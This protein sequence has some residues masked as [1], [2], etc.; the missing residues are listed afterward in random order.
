VW[1]LNAQGQSSA[2]AYAVTVT[3]QYYKTESRLELIASSAEAERQR[4]ETDFRPLTQY[5]TKKVEMPFDPTYYQSQFSSS[6]MSSR[7]YQTILPDE[8]GSGALWTKGEIKQE[9]V[10]GEKWWKQQSHRWQHYAR[11]VPWM[12]AINGTRGTYYAGAWTVF[13]MHELAITS[14]FAAAYRLGADFPH[15]GD[16]KCMRLF[17]LYLCLSHAARLRKRDR[18]GAQA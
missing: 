10:I 16:E 7:V 3:E 12:W 18:K 9:L 13:N 2:S 17:R 5:Y 11:V 8:D 1:T 4:G 14:G 6:A 15:L